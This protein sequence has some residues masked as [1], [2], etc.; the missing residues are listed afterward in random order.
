MAK[1]W[2]L[3]KEK[4]EAFKKSDPGQMLKKPF[5]HVYPMTGERQ[6]IKTVE[7]AINRVA[8]TMNKPNANSSPQEQDKIMQGQTDALIARLLELNSEFSDRPE[9]FEF[10]V[11]K[12]VEVFAT[13]KLVPASK[14]KTYELLKECLLDN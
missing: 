1:G 4:M 10:A 5:F 8:N 13:T 7:E 12:T 6:L 9:I 14:Q 2:V 3:L 11:F